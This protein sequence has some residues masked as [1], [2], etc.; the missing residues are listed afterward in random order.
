MGKLDE[1]ERTMAA[2]EKWNGTFQPNC[3]PQKCVVPLPLFLF[4]GTYEA[5]VAADITKMRVRNKDN[6]DDTVRQHDTVKKSKTVAGD[7][8]SFVT[9]GIEDR[10][11]DNNDRAGSDI[12]DDEGNDYFE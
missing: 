7:N 4:F 8:D 2:L 9:C 12:E 3:M 1:M 10:E 11:Y 6:Y 5:E